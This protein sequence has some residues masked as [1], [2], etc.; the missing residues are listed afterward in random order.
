MIPTPAACHGIEVLTLPSNTASAHTNYMTD[1][2]GMTSNNEVENIPGAL[3]IGIRICYWICENWS[4]CYDRKFD[5]CINTKIHFT[6][7]LSFTV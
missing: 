6:T 5:F 4:H 3:S 7:L 2:G 1:T